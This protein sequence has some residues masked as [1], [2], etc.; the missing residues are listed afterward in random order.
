MIELN[1]ITTNGPSIN[2]IGS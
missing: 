2:D 1:A